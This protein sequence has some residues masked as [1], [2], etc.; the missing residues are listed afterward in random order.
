MI[1]FDYFY[2]THSPEHI[3]LTQELYTR[4]KKNG[5][6]YKGKVKQY[7][8]SESQEPLPDRYVTGTCPHCNAEEQY[9][10]HCEKC[11]KALQGG[12]LINP[13]SKKTNTP[14][15]VRDGEHIF[16]K[17]S[18]FS[19]QLKK[20][21]GEVEAP[22]EIKNFVLSWVK[23]GLQDWDIERDISWGVPIPDSKGVFYVWFD[24]PIGYASTLKKWCK[25]KSE[26]FDEWWNSRLVHFIGKD[27]AYHHFL[28]WPAIL[29]G[30]GMNIPASIPVRGHLTLEGKKF[31]K[32]RSH[33]ISV[34]QWKD[35]GL[36]PEYLRFY[37][38]YTTSLGVK[39]SDFSASEYKKVVNEELV[40]NF[41]NLLQRVLKFS[42]RLNSVIPNVKLDKEF[43]DVK[44]LRTEYLKLMNE[45]K[46]SK[47]LKL[48]CFGVRNL[49]R[50]FQEKAPWKNEADAPVVVAT[51]A[52]SIKLIN[53]M[54]YPFLPERTK[55]VAG[56]LNVGLRWE[57]TSLKPGHVLEKAEILFPR[58]E[59]STVKKLSSIY[60]A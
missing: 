24:A 56:L 35:K 30:S 22:K 7:W 36:D 38:T 23:D 17:L 43:E 27:I 14:A 4:L 6:I 50:Y 53:E 20:F 11:G 29:M 51:V 44:K 2:A 1:D 48:V 25:E 16:F 49:N 21:V 59:D 45:G 58:V 18:G 34:A 39:D 15:E 46:L 28:F 31:S 42:E 26:D 3:E 40:N 41:G 54:L 13:I 5:H 8:D 47:A 9:A 37:M 19:K 57:T 12:E 10:D 55:K 32:S 60:N 33:Y 52:S